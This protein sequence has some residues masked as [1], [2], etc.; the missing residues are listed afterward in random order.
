MKILYCHWLNDIESIYG[1]KYFLE[2]PHVKCFINKDNSIDYCCGFRLSIDQWKEKIFQYDLCIIYNGSRPEIINCRFACEELKKSTIYFECG[3]FPQ[4]ET[5]ITDTKGIIGKSSL[6]ENI[7]WVSKNNI[8]KFLKFKKNYIK[9]FKKCKKEIDIL[10]PTQMEWDCSI[11]LHSPFKTMIEFIEYCDNKFNGRQVVYKIHPRDF[12]NFKKYCD[13]TKNECVISDIKNKKS[14]ME[15]ANK[16]NF[17][18]G[19]NSTSL[20]ES[21]ILGIPTESIGNGILKSHGISWKSSEEK[22]NQVLCAVWL[23]Q[24]HYKEKITVMRLLNVSSN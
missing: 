17:V 16:S 1:S 4:H 6:C 19:I 15:F 21:L 3:I 18:F 5:I 7:S 24:F 8:E 10:I 11:Q 12:N 9:S 20:F 13:V 2:L 22:I 23:K 14:F